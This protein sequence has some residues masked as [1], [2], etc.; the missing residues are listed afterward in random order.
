MNPWEYPVA[1]TNS[2]YT[3]YIPLSPEMEGK[4]IELIVLGMKGGQADFTPTAYLCCYPEPFEEKEL[5]LYRK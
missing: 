2:H 1:Q 3:Y 4:E 5:V